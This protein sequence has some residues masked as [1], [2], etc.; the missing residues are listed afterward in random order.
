MRH[1]EILRLSAFFLLG[2]KNHMCQETSLRRTGRWTVEN[3]FVQVSFLMFLD[4]S[5]KEVET[6]RPYE[7]M[8]NLRALKFLPSRYRWR[9]E[10]WTP[11]QM[12]SD[13]TICRKRQKAKKQKSFIAKRLWKLTCATKEIMNVYTYT[14]ILHVCYIIIRLS[15][16][17]RKRYTMGHMPGIPRRQQDEF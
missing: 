6:W 14:D 4:V 5:S 2:P 7:T 15:T 16:K 3:E 12:G 8:W 10:A 17:R 13:K 11:R 1:A 9:Q